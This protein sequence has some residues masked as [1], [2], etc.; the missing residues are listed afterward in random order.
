MPNAS[1][2]DLLCFNGI[3]GATGDYLLPPLSA[4]EISG[5]AQRIA[6]HVIPVT[7]VTERK[8]HVLRNGNGTAS[9]DAPTQD[10]G[11]WRHVRTSDVRLCPQDK[12]NTNHHH[13]QGKPLAHGCS[14]RQ[15]ADLHVGL[16]KQLPDYS[17]DAVAEKKGSG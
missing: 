10:L 11:Q 1:D 7:R 5:L 8:R 14:E 17:K 6:S 9:C 2:Q 12:K 13:G 4:H 3:N 16:T 15:K